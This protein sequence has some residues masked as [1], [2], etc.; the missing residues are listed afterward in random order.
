MKS[1]VVTLGVEKAP[2][3]SLLKSMGLTAE[4]IRRP[5]I[6]VVN[7]FNEIVPGHK[8]LRQVAE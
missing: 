7:T 3:R 4:E 1:H 6:G 2:H 8:H 5:L